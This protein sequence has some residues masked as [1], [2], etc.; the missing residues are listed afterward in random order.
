MKK[1]EKDLS[2]AP[3][4]QPGIILFARLSGFVFG[5]VIL[6]VFLGRWLDRKFQT[7]PWLFLFTVGAA[8]F[9]S[10]SGMV[11]EALKEMRRIEKEEKKDPKE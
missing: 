11:K 8:F 9:V 2:K 10:M 4:W 3:W 5:P 7:E 6:A 1:T